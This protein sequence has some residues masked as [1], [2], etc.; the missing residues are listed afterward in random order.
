MRG[1]APNN[2]NTAQEAN[3]YIQHVRSLVSARAYQPA[4]NVF[5]S[6]Q[7]STNRTYQSRNQLTNRLIDGTHSLSNTLTPSAHY[8]LASSLILEMK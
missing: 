1:R 6:Q 2:I 5:L 7:T 3:N 8:S 4:N